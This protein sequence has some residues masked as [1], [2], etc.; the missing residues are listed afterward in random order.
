M[1]IEP[2]KNLTKADLKQLD[3]FLSRDRNPAPMNLTI[4]HGFFSAILSAPSLILPSRYNPYLFGGNP[5]FESEIQAQVI[6]SLILTLRL[7]VNT[8][9]NKKIFKPLL[10][11][12][13]KIEEYQTA[14]MDLISQ[15]C[16]G[17]CLGVQV[18][19]QWTSNNNALS[20]LLP[21]TILSNQGDY[22]IENSTINYLVQ[23]SDVHKEAYRSHLPNY[24]KE[25]Y[26]YWESSRRNPE[27]IV[28]EDEEV[29]WL[30]PKTMPDALCPCDSGKKFIDCCGFK[31]IH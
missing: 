13:G 1:N 27:P 31:I 3:K 23:G 8:E 18:D 25:F 10:W 14:S 22:E 11:S 4:A 2:Q 28:G 5:E 26:K 17:Y 21:F 16:F 15:W 12:N 24:V 20:Q 29:Y 9:L 30:E 6:L 7:Q 19:P